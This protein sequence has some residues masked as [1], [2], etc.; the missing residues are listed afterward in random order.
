MEIVV[1]EIWTATLDQMVS[2]TFDESKLYD[3]YYDYP[4]LLLP[5]TIT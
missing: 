4:K 2:K 5:K 3:Q 1:V